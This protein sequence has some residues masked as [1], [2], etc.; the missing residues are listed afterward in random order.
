VEKSARHGTVKLGR[1]Q[2]LPMGNIVNGINESRALAAIARGVGRD[3]GGSSNVSHITSPYIKRPLFQYDA[4]SI[5]DH[6][7][8]HEIERLMMPSH[9]NTSVKASE[10]GDRHTIKW[11]FKGQKRETHTEEYPCWLVAE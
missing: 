1:G 7:H 11:R 6:H 2:I 4:M 3:L 8:G 5:I 9:T 10:I